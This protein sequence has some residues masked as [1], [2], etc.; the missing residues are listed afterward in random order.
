MSSNDYESNM[1]HGNMI[2]SYFV[3]SYASGINY[4][5]FPKYPDVHFVQI[6]LIICFTTN[7]RKHV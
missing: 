7:K 3:N 6:F 5:F 2:F 4:L 1:I